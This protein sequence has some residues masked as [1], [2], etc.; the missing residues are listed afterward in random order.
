[1]G[2]LTFQ[3]SSINTFCE[4]R[5]GLPARCFALFTVDWRGTTRAEDDQGTPTQSHVSPSIPVY[6]PLMNLFDAGTEAA[7]GG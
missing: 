4:I 2:E 6:A 7:W 5:S 1:M 3:A